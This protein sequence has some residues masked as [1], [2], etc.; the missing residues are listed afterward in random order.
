M[1][2]FPEQVYKTTI[3]SATTTYRERLA[4][5]NLYGTR[6]RDCGALSYPRRSNCSRCHS[7]NMESIEMPHTG[8]VFEVSIVENPGGGMMGWGELGIRATVLVELSNGVKV[9]AEIVDEE[10]PLLLKP[11]TPVKMVLRKLRRASNSDW[12]YGYKFIVD[13][14]STEQ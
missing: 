3:T 10:N 13:R 12:S 6:C 4:R 5:Y 7:R 14:D 2:Q 8:K 1:S 9:F 11:G